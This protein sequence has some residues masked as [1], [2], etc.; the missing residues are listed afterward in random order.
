MVAEIV[1]ALA[2][3]LGDRIG[4]LISVVLG[5]LVE[6]V[7]SFTAPVSGPYHLMAISVAGAVITNCLPIL[8]AST[9]LAARRKPTIDIHPYSTG[10]QSQ[11]LLISTIFLAIPTVFYLLLNE[12]FTDRGSSFDNLAFY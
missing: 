7:A 5:N 12:K 1:E 6:L 11:H 10:L 2:E 9:C 4:G 3:K 8:G